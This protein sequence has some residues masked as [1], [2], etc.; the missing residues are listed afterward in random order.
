MWPYFRGDDRLGWIDKVVETIS[1]AAGYKREAWRKA[2][3]DL[4][5]YDAGHGGRLNAGW[6]ASNQAAESGDR[7]DRDIVRARARDL[8]RNSDISESLV[9]AYVRNVVGRGFTLQAKTSSPELNDQIESTWKRWCKA[10]NCDVTGEQDL[11]DILRMAVRR[12]KIDGGMLIVKRYMPGGV[13]PL[14]LQCLEVDE[15]D[16]SAYAPKFVK[17]TV[18]GGIEYNPWKKPVGYW[19]RQYDVN[20]WQTIDPVFLRAEDVIFYYEKKRP[21]QI[22]EMSDMSVTLPRIRNATEFE[23]AVSVKERIAACLAVFIK[24]TIPTGGLGR[25][26]VVTPD[27]HVDYADKSLTPGMIKEMNAGDEIQVVDPKGAATDATTFMKTELAMAGAGQGLSYEAASRDLSQTNYSS[28]RQGSIEDGMTYDLEIDRLLSHVLSEIY[29]TFLISGYL[30]GVFDMPGFF[31]SKEAFMAHEWVGS[32]KK[33]IDPQKEANANKT[34]LDSG[35]KTYKQVAAEAGRDWKTMIDDIAEVND[36]AKKKGVSIFNSSASGGV[37]DD[38]ANNA[39]GDEDDA[40][41]KGGEDPN[42]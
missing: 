29:E 23:T 13:V 24:K 31:D 8:E 41:E 27:G 6:Y 39:D 15:L 21:S 4:R 16:G 40:G 17:D 34:A 33:W 9:L 26:G 2:T 19:I 14:R 1:P 38:V 28:A 37:S 30:S 10:A 11:M 42:A 22:R 18:V 5:W 20:G 36:Y 3:E 35:Q 7:I 32:P 25:S 12:K